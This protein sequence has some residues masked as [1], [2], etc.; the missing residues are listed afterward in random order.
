MG[1]LIGIVRVATERVVKMALITMTR[2]QDHPH[3]RG[4]AQAE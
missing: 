3:H 2:I 1:H 4:T